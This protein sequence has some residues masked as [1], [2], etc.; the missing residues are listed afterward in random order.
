MSDFITPIV[1][2]DV[3][4]TS[5]KLALF[6]SGG[7]GP[8]PTPAREIRLPTTGDWTP[9]DDWWRCLVDE[10]GAS[11]ADAAWFVSSVHRGGLERIVNWVERQA[12]AQ[13]LH[14]LSHGD[15]PLAIDVAQPER[16]GMDRLMAAVAADARRGPYE[17]A[18]L[19]DSG[20]AVTVD[21]VTA[22]AGFCG[23]AILP[24]RGLA[25]KSLADHTD[26]LPLA[27]SQFD[28]PPPAVGRT[29]LEAIASGLYWGVVGA[30]RELVQQ[31]SNDLRREPLVLVGGGLGQLLV[32][33]LQHNVEFAP[34]LVLEG[35][36]L[37]ARAVLRGEP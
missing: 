31:I 21:L 1:A 20:T 33:H 22:A 25:A 7:S 19:V 9:L 32:E 27:S 11:A 17:S 23:G 18:V 26:L 4:N 36:A 3:G 10:A 35:I 24:G 34:D 5:T 14:V 12:L 30:V 6:S 2:V 8:T 16:V 37:T 15:V 28:T 13:S 29:T